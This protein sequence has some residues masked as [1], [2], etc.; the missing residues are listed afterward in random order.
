MLR[1]LSSFS[2][3]NNLKLFSCGINTYETIRKNENAFA[4][5]PS[6]ATQ[7]ERA[8]MFSA[9]YFTRA[10]AIS[11][12]TNSLKENERG[13]SFTDGWMKTSDRKPKYPDYSKNPLSVI[14]C[15][16]MND[17]N[18]IFIPTSK[19]ESVSSVLMSLKG[20]IVE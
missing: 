4:L 7:C 16:V 11:L 17:L 19:E 18:V 8:G 6:S 1:I 3:S 2:E 12:K 5:M 14:D 9:R 13:E 10:T 15:L 20:N